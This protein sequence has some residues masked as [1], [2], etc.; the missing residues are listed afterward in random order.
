MG[1]TRGGYKD[2]PFM[3]EVI[4][5]GRITIPEEVR[6]VLKIVKGD[7]VTVPKIKVTKVRKPKNSAKSD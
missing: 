3:A 6:R 7:I 5:D 2:C 4:E 1:K